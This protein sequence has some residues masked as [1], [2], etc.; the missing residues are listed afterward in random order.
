MNEIMSEVKEYKQQSD[1]QR[2][3]K[4]YEKKALEGMPL[5]SIVIPSFNQAHLLDPTLEALFR[6]K[7]AHFEVIIV[8]AGS[9]DTTYALL[10][11]YS[12]SISR[13]YYATKYNVPLM[14]NK[15][16]S[17]AKGNYVSFLL[18][19]SEYVNLFGLCQISRVALENN[20]PDYI[21]AA[22]NH[23][24]EALK[25]YSQVLSESLSDLH[26]AFTLYPFSKDYLRRGFSPSSP[27]CMW[28]KRETF[29]DVGQLNDNYSFVKSIFDLVCRLYLKKETRSATTFWVM[30]DTGWHDKD[31][32]TMNALFEKWPLILK[33][34]GPWQGFLWF[35]RDKPV[36]IL[37][38]FLKTLHT[39]FKSPT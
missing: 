29:L 19:G 3:K 15:G 7:N 28:F 33:Y 21:Y 1:W 11:T 31:F 27:I 39:I 25:D 20:L 2:V 36:H 23:I 12:H 9:T 38:W 6:Q 24:E 34:F 26:P 16:V 5:I 37:S 4:H 22:D 13:I 35:F 14:L 17:L 18:P 32:V 10:Q 30:S 8:D